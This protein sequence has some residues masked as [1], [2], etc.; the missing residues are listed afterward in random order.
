[1]TFDLE[2]RL[3]VT[4]SSRNVSR[5]TIM[6]VWRDKTHSEWFGFYIEKIKYRKK[7]TV[8]SQWRCGL[9]PDTP[10]T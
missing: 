7:N 6:E 5:F 3:K 9:R 10:D 8:H 4:G 1:V 2:L